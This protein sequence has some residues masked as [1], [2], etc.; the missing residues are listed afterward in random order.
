[1]ALQGSLHDLALPD[2]IQLVSVAGKTGVFTLSGEGVE[3]KI[4]LRDGQVIDAQVG[5]L[6]GEGA[7]YQMAMWRSGGFIFTPGIEPDQPTISRSN[8]SLMMEA[9]RRH[10]EWRVL[11][12]KIPSLDAVPYFLPRD[13]RHDQITLSPVEWQVVTSIDGQRS[14]TQLESVTGLPAFDVCKVLFG[15]ITSGLIALREQEQKAPVNR[16]AAPSV[17]SLLA[18]VEN[19]RKLAEDTVG[20]AGSITVEKQYRLVRA[21]IEAGGGLP[22]VQRM[23]ETLA[24]AIALL[25]GNDRATEF[26]RRVKPLIQR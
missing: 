5:A 20:L 15:L 9:A 6:R 7:L 13:P 10:D 23:I 21:E 25:E 12:R 24:R 22:A 14:V 8:T 18:L 19:V 1:M 16:P 2:V 4:Y 11:Q 26:A 3:G 17:N